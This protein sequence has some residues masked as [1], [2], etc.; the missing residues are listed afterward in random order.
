MSKS[1]LAASLLGASVTLLSGCTT[2]CPVYESPISESDAAHAEAAHHAY[3]DVINANDLEA[4]LA[5]TTEDVVFLPPHGPRIVG[6]QSLREWATPYLE[7]YT[8]NWDKRVLEFTMLSPNHAF[9]QYSYVENDTAKDGSHTLED[10]GKGVIL[11]ERGDD[12]VWRVARDIWCTD[13]PPQ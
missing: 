5:M 3:T 9:E 8:V 12:N 10:T 2:S 13:L 7:A 4:F 6:Q 1:L 11:W